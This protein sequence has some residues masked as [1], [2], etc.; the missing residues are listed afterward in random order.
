MLR[1]SITT[2]LSKVLVLVLGLAVSVIIARTLGPSW[3]GAL[4][5]VLLPQAIFLKTATLGIDRGN[6]YYCG[7]EPGRLGD[8][9]LYSLWSGLII[10]GA[11]FILLLL[12]AM[13]GQFKSFTGHIDMGFFIVI[14]ATFPFVLVASFYDAIVYGRN[15]IL[16][17]N[18]KEIA[19][20][21]L[22]L[23]F[24]LLGFFVLHKKL[25][26]VVGA[27]FA[28]AV[29]GCAIAVYLVH[30]YVIPLRLAKVDW[31]Y[32]RMNFPF[33]FKN[34][35][36]FAAVALIGSLII[37]FARYRLPQE[38]LGMRLEQIAFLSMAVAFIE[39]GITFP[40]SIVFALIPKIT[41]ADA[42]EA[43][44]MLLKASRYNILLTLLF[45]AVLFYT[46]DWIVLILYDTP[47][48]PMAEPFKALVPGA[49]FLSLGE[50]WAAGLFARGRAN[51]ILAAGILG[52]IAGAVSGYYLLATW[53][54]FGGAVAVSFGF[55]V[56][57]LVLLVAY[58]IEAPFRSR[59]MFVLSGLDF[60][61]I[62]TRL[63]MKRLD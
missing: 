6:I 36:S 13:T 55:F 16:L 25:L 24:V 27:T 9:A 50:I 61:E 22:L 59:D 19:L 40:R 5:L 28:T 53:S 44:R 43:I 57:A 3:R 1:D 47:F 32:F 7:K 52:L 54:I 45:Y 30:R 20:N 60:E 33:G 38:S 39:R 51:A 26:A 18:L 12:Y 8:I 56:Y 41:G 37:L 4:A 2:I 21:A 29:V 62:K 35:V 48:A 46:I 17:R 42:R 14:A 34:H 15:L 58:A 63:G 31:E 49:I 23:V 10:G 11:A